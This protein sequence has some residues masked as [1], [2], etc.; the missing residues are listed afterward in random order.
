MNKAQKNFVSAFINILLLLILFFMHYGGITFAIGRAIPIILIPLVLSVAVCYGENL[1]L[2]A[3]FFAGTLM[4]SAAS[5]TSLFNT[6]FMVIGC[7][8][9]GI[10]SS[11]VLNRN[12]KSAICLSGGLSFGYFFV[13][14]LV[15]F[16]FNGTAANYDYFVS[17]L[18]P[19]AVYTAIW[20][21]PFYFLQKKL[22]SL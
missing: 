21:I 15:F 14:Y 5:E 4:D 12:L 18:I 1:G 10:L 20:I 17:Y 3:G 2:L 19:S 7:T 13:K 9:C 6:L 8:V 16:A 22:S 11:R